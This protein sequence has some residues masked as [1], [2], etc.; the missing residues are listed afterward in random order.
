ML[1]TRALFLLV[2]MPAADPGVPPVMSRLE[3]LFRR[4]AQGRCL[5]V[6]STLLVVVA[7]V[8]LASVSFFLERDRYRERARVATQNVTALLEAKLAGDFRRVDLAIANFAVEFMRDARQGAVSSARLE[9]AVDLLGALFPE[10][11]SLGVLD[12]QGALQQARPFPSGRGGDFSDRTYFTAA[13]ENPHRGLIVDGP[14]RSRLSQR[15]VVVFSYPLRDADGRFAGV[16][17]AALSSEYFHGVLTRADLGRHGAATVRT[18]DLALVYR[19]P[20]PELADIGSRNVSDQLRRAAAAA[21]GGGEF[22][23]STALDGIERSN[24]YRPVE[25]YPFYVL[26]GM[27]TEDF[28]GDWRRNTALIGVFSGALLLTVLFVLAA[29]YRL[30]RQQAAVGQA[31][32]AEA[33]RFQTVLRT[34]ADGIHV[35]DRQGRRVLA[36]PAFFAL[37]GRDE[38]DGGNLRVGDWDPGTEAGMVTGA[39]AGGCAPGQVRQFATRYRQANGAM[40]D[41]DVN[42]SRFRLGSE[43]FVVASARDVTEKKRTV[44]MLEFMLGE[45]RKLNDELAFRARQAEAANRAKDAFLANVSHELRTPLNGIMGMTQ[46]VQ[47]KL[48]D[49][50]LRARL[51]KV[52]QASRHLRAIINDLLDISRIEAGRIV[53]EETEFTLQ[54]LVDSLRGLLGDAA[55]EKGLALSI[56]VPPALAWRTL[57]GDPVRLEQILLNLTG[58]AI[59]FTSAGSIDV[60]AELIGETPGSVIVR[61]AVRDTG[62]GIAAEEQQR[63][64]TA[65]GQAAASL[66]RRYGGIGLGLAISKRLIDLMGG[67][68]GVESAP[69]RGALFWFTVRLAPSDRPP[70]V[71]WKAQPL[72]ASAVDDEAELRRRFPGARIL[73]VEDEP[74][75][76]EFVMGL[77]AEAGLVVVFAGDGQVAVEQ[78]EAADFDLILM[79]MLLPR[80]D[81]IEAARR[82]R[83]LPR[84]ARTP[85]LVLTAS[86]SE[87]TRAECT[88]GGMNGILLKPVLAGQLFRA[89]LQ[90]LT[91][92]RA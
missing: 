29:L 90:A 70:S 20:R 71:A 64:F 87:T 86:A 81:G 44:E 58:N 65:F 42:L 76:R 22:V 59:K 4:C 11:E 34:S 83:K 91:V 8:A 43:E 6:A 69:G 33:E 14:F 38:N 88:R 46:L 84:H 51:E 68:V 35:L 75:H 92:P 24:A 73:V 28:L 74:I 23:A 16:V 80:L 79:D 48:P 13:R 30:S 45:H 26:V 15:P 32:A 25:G 50:A 62:I 78:A 7:V 1:W 61:F 41:V 19:N 36:N 85:I 40:R 82:I 77:L 57:Y 52:M 9:R 56:D 54:A 21:P 2:I 47:R 89:V 17:F 55:R 53:L 5:F 72:E 39:A 27:A 66:S 67:E 49:P 3:R 63:L 37:I 10:L 12:H 18:A 31:L 60:Q